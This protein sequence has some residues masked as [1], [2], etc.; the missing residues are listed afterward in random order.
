MGHYVISLKTTRKEIVPGK[1]IVLYYKGW[2]SPYFQSIEGS[3]LEVSPSC[4]L[5]FERHVF[6]P[7]AGVRLKVGN[8]EADELTFK[9][10]FEYRDVFG[11]EGEID[12]EY[13]IPVK[14]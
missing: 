3:S 1:D 5:S 9:A 2:D 10:R 7:T 13:K 4:D 6:Y 14:K 8:T 12:S 11:E